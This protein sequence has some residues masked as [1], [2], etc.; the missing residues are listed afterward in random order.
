MARACGQAGWR[1]RGR[2]FARVVS[3]LVLTAGLSVPG[4]AEERP[5]RY[6]ADTGPLRIRDQFLLGIGFVAFDPSSAE[7][8]A[9]GKWQV[10]LILT[11]SNDFARSGPI[12]DVLDARTDRQSLTLGQLR[13]AASESSSGGGFLTD[14]EHYRTAFAVRRGVNER[15]QVEL[16]VPIISFRGGFLDSTVEG[17]HD[18]LSLGQMGRLGVPRDAFQ[19]YVKGS[20]RELFVDH[21]PGAALGDVVLGAKLALLPESS[22]PSLRV[23]AEALLKLPTGNVDRFAGSGSTDVGVQVLATKY[24]GRSSLHASLGLAYLGEMQRLG[25]SAQAVLSGMMAFERALGSRTSVLVQATVSQSP[26]GELQLARL[27]ET[28]TQVTLGLKR[29]LG[30]QV[31][32]IGITENVGHFNNSPDIGFHLGLTRIF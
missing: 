30:K 24:L 10:D 20:Q 3:P 31:L 25:L 11:V 12:A 16:T 28:S 4:S 1:R 23:S 29:V 22:S 32:L 21:A 13:D 2:A 18:A 27:S 19:V 17:F 14:G 7:L 8:L 9:P 15:L 26:F 6:L 5:E